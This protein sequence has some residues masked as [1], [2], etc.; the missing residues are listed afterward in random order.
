MAGSTSV[1]VNSNYSGFEAGEIIG[2]AF[3]EADTLRLGLITM[4]PNVST[5]LNL[6]KIEYTNGTVDYSCGFTPEGAIVLSE[7][8]VEPKKVMNALQ[9]C[10]EDFIATWSGGMGS[11]SNPNFPQDIMNAITVELLSD[12]AEKIDNEIWHGVLATS[13]QI[14]GLVPQFDADGDVIKVGNGIT[15]IGAVTDESNVEAN[16]KIALNAIPQALRRSK[17]LT[18][19]VS[20]NIFQA[21]MFYLI[22]KGISN[23]GNTDSKQTKFGKYVLTEVNGLDD[24]HIIIFDKK[25]VVFATAL[26][27][28]FNALAMVDE[29][30]INLLTG[31]IRGK[32]VYSAGLGY[33]NGEEIVY[34]DTTA[35]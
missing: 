20:S 28:D 7:K 29:D 31:M 12:Q 23:D 30:S 3:L 4:A 19:A 11:A 35:V 13:G 25:N 2:K 10:K 5:V 33:Y 8:R 24:D 34:L 26:Q 14:G 15:S 1:T 18:V 21:Y 16:L 9:I 22:S 6:R 32:L 17:S 27:A